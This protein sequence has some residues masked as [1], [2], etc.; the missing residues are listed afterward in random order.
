MSDQ[1]I[2]VHSD[3]ETESNEMVDLAA[4]VAQH[5]LTNAMHRHERQM[6]ETLGNINHVNNLARLAGFEK[7]NELG[8]IESRSN[9]GVMATPI[10]SPTLPVQ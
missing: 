7:F 1:E 9:S 6:E 2:V 10:A 5:M 4:N 8:T 3:R